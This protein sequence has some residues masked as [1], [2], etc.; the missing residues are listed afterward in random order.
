MLFVA[1]LAALAAGCAPRSSSLPPAPPVFQPAAEATASTTISI[2]IPQ[3]QQTSTFSRRALYV[4]SA[5]NSLV[6]T[7]QGQSP[8]VIPLTATSP[9]C[10]IVS[11]ARTCAISTSLP[12]G[13]YTVTV[14]LY[15]SVDGTGTPL[16]IVATLQTIVQNATNNLAF[17]LNAVVAAIG[18]TIVPDG[19]FAV[20]SAASR[21]VNVAVVD[22]AAATIVMGK[23]A[24]VDSKGS[25]VTI[26]LGNTDASGATVLSP[27]TAGASPSTLSYNGAASNGGIVTATAVNASNVSVASSNT[28]FIV[29]SGPACSGLVSPSA[30]RRVDTN[31]CTQ[32]IPVPTPF[33]SPPLTCGGQV[34]AGMCLAWQYDQGMYTPGRVNTV[35]D[36]QMSQIAPGS[37]WWYGS[38]AN[39]NGDGIIVTFNG[40]HVGNGTASYVVP[41]GTDSEVVCPALHIYLDSGLDLINNARP[42]MGQ[43]GS[44]YTSYDEHPGYDFYAQE[45]SEVKA[46]AD[47]YVV[48]YHL[49]RCIPTGIE[50][51]VHTATDGPASCNGWGYVGIDHMNG[52]VS[53]YGHLN[54]STITVDVGNWVPRG[55]TIGYSSWTGLG[56]S[57]AAH[58][59][60]EVLA[61]VVNDQTNYY[62]PENWE[63][64]DPYGWTDGIVDRPA[65]DPL[66]S[67]QT[68]HIKSTKLWK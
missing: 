54:V 46:V 64:V 30:A 60:F 16:A 43:C 21:T 3:G 55:T 28:S 6:L 8:I 24:L 33:M 5:T 44:D 18:V 25:A 48:G 11:G 29:T 17:T 47:G 53:Q 35:L 12:I 4:S 65:G 7:P 10:R 22:A 13:T 9:G 57:S 19:T 39:G 42:P 2:R 34:S 26:R 41:F 63:V 49:G 20:G 66:D 37:P 45:H 67:W 14:A 40:A 58:L 23:D 59:H 27:V 1:V 31:S 61:R 51:K 50:V 15:A 36:H 62:A 38:L 52:Y 56:S 68:Y 32:P